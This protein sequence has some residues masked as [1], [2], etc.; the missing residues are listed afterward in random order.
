MLPIN[1]LSNSIPI[2]G[3]SDWIGPDQKQKVGSKK[4]E[5]QILRRVI[6]PCGRWRSLIE[7]VLS[8]SLS[9][10]LSLT[11][12]LSSLSH[13]ISNAIRLPFIWL[14]YLFVLFI[15]FVQPLSLLLFF[16][17]SLRTVSL[18]LSLSLELCIFWIGE[19]FYI[20]CTH[21]SSAHCCCFFCFVFFFQFF[22]LCT[23]VWRGGYGE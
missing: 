4:N 21:Q 11:L 16:F 18:S 17:F 7:C 10:S 2:Q 23:F 14:Y 6:H 12:S 3:N 5:I 20:F 19:K 13:T 15:R 8:Y 22:I 1:Y 9:L